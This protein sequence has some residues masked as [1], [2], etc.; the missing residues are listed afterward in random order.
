MITLEIFADNYQSILNAQQ[1]N[2][3]RLELCSAL[4]VE[5]LTPSP[6]LVKFAKANFKAHY[7][8][9]FSIVVVIYYDQVD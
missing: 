3:D 2:A 8:L 4:D 6:S 1:A 7:K 9:W 5:W